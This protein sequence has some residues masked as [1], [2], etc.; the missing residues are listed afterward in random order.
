MS[1]E[2]IAKVKACKNTEEMLSVAKEEGI[3]LTDE[4]LEAVNGGACT[5]TV[6]P[7]KGYGRSAKCPNCGRYGWCEM[8]KK[9]GGTRQYLKS[10]D[11]GTEFWW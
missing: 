2:Q 8:L 11:C 6:T 4:Q 1:E 9:K 7:G 3:Q 10:P 5:E